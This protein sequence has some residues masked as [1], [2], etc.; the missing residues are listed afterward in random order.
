MSEVLIRLRT[1]LQCDD[2]VVNTYKITRW[3][4]EL[5]NTKNVYENDKTMKMAVSC[6]RTKDGLVGKCLW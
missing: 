4:S 6:S 2:K 3:I 5:F 1:D